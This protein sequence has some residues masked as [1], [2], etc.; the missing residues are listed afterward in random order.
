MTGGVSFLCLLL[1]GVVERLADEH[2]APSTGGG[3]EG[4]PL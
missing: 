3:G 1:R 4:S 2:S